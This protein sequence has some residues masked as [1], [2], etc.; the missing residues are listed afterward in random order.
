MTNSITKLILTDRHR[1]S[2][3]TSE[4]TLLISTQSDRARLLYSAPFRRLQQKAQVFSLESNSAV[5]SRLTHSIEVSHIGRY[6]TSKIQ[7]LIQDKKD[8][9][10]KGYWNANSL[11]ISN[12]VENAC[13]MHDIGNPPFGHFGEAAISEWFTSSHA[14]NVLKESLNLKKLNKNHKEVCLSD[15]QSF[16]G[17]PQG[18][19]LITK[20]QGDDGKTGL[21]LTYTQLAAFLKYT[22]SPLNKDKNEPFRKKAGF[23]STEKDIIDGAWEALG[24]G[25]NTR[26]PLSFI[27]EA[28]DDISYCISD[29]EDGIEKRIISEE[30]FFTNFNER[31]L[32]LNDA[33]EKKKSDHSISDELIKLKKHAS[34]V[35]EF[36]MFKTTLSNLLVDNVAYLFVDDYDTFMNCSRTQE[37][38]HKDTEA[39][40]ILKILKDFSSDYLFSS[41]EAE[42]MELSGYAVISGLLEVYSKLLQLPRDKFSLIVDNEDIRKNKLDIH[43]RLF[44]RLPATYV[45][46]YI[47]CSERV[48]DDKEWNLRAHLI[49]D[50]ISGMTDNFSL[51]TYKMLKGIRVT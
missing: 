31:L 24:M 23:F 43:K 17:N 48:K 34:A 15:F 37:I 13:L 7:E 30:F 8:D 49:V 40:K 36:M 44:N 1:P 14:E 5:R 21:N 29:I 2:T 18:F 10:V 3:A 50:F 16:D 41:K 45:N 46:S 33:L 42:T 6:I 26:H 51:E 47:K 9:D 27:M 35:S 20:L 32:K 19:R 22:S 12:I 38:I 39:F 4:P 25:K 28:S 11:V